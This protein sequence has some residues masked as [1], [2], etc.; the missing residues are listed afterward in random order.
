MILLEP[1]NT[2]THCKMEIKR[3]TISL[4]G[5][6]EAIGLQEELYASPFASVMPQY[7]LSFR[8][9]GQWEALMTP[10]WSFL[11]HSIPFD[12]PFA[13]HGKGAI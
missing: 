9:D 5:F 1:A 13:W 7:W 8:Y 10:A 3:R 2:I 11:R 6:A 12:D 4:T